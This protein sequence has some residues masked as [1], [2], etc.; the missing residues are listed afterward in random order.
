VLARGNGRQRLFHGEDDYQRVLQGL[1]H[2]P[3]GSNSFNRKPQASVK[4]NGVYRRANCGARLRLAVKRVMRTTS[5]C[6]E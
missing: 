5:K 1:D 6:H 3:L 4:A 2:S